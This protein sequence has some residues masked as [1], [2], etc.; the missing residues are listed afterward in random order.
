MLNRMVLGV[1]RSKIVVQQEVDGCSAELPILQFH[2]LRL[3]RH[4][5]RLCVLRELICTP[6]GYT[7][8]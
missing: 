4:S 5:L 1:S 7:R 6:L 8:V 2:T 3:T